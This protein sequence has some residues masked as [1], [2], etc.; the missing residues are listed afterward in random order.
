MKETIKCLKCETLCTKMLQFGQ[1][2]K[3]NCQHRHKLS[4]QDEPPRYLDQIKNVI[5]F[6]MISMQGPTTFV[7]SIREYYDNKWIPYDQS[8]QK[9][10]NDMQNFCAEKKSTL[11]LTAGKVGDVYAK[12]DNG[13]GKWIRGKMIKR[14]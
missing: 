2:N 10:E 7:I 11:A 9:L 13:L 1:C 4:K 12:Y 8:Q 3:F 5:R 6:D 14:K